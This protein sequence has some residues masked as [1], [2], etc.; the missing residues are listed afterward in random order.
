MT[1]SD[2][3]AGLPTGVDVR[4]TEESA[5]RK[6]AT[7]LAEVRSAAYALG[8]RRGIE[9]LEL[10]VIKL[11]RGRGWSKSAIARDIRGSIAEL[12]RRVEDGRL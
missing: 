7:A 6:V 4:E 11:E 2:L 1:T 5:Q 8:I 10:A 9:A 12:K 3:A